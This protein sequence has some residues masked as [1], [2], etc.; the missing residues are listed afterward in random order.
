MVCFE[1]SVSELITNISWFRE[2]AE[3]LGQAKPP[4]VTEEEIERSGLELF[5]AGSL[6]EYEASGRVASNCV[7]RVSICLDLSCFSVDIFSLKKVS[8]LS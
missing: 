5:K 7:D 8:H 6:K 3:F 4:V 2:L 1:G